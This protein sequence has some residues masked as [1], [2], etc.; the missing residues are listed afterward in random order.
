[1]AALQFKSIYIYHLLLWIILIVFKVILDISIYKEISLS[2]NLQ[3]FS[4]SLVLFYFNYCVF[5]P[6]LVQQSKQKIILWI[7]ALTIIY[8]ALLIFSFPK[9][10][11]K[12]TTIST[13][14]LKAL[15]TVSTNGQK[16]PLSS[17][18]S[19]T[20]AV[21]QT[22]PFARPMTLEQMNLP[23][24]PAIPSPVLSLNNILSS[25]AFFALMFSTILFFI[26]KWTEN[27]KRV[28]KLE[29]ERQSNELHI[30]REQI[31]PHFFFNALNSIY[32]LSLVKSDETAKIIVTLS[33]IMRYA[34]QHTTKTEQ[35]NNLNSEI[36]N[37]KKY[38]E[39]Q[40]IRFRKYNNIKTHFEGE[41]S[42]CVI[43]PLLL[44]TFVENAFK[45]VNIKK[46][47]LEI[48]IALIENHLT[49]YTFH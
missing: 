45:Y 47:P 37:I 20:P 38:I 18:S 10:I 33:D 15:T 42:R 8:I 46:G 26:D 27:E 12:L 35:K 25:I 36:E 43:E 19:Q 34:F 13:D 31:N 30:L 3:I 7:V 49:F 22:P 44:L 14:E 4:L 40:S 2:D 23:A 29:Y 39:I 41:F 1:M 5:L 21:L 11:P 48:K 24:T 32:S 16:I 9:T 17:S 6:F 28:Q